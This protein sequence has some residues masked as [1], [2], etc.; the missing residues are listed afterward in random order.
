MAVII[1]KL[2]VLFNVSVSD[3]LDK[4][5]KEKTISENT[6]GYKLKT[7]ASKNCLPSITVEVGSLSKV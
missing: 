7:Y 6:K 3:G 4:I 2:A 5:K 1:L